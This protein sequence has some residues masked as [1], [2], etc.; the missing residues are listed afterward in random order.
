VI[1][2][3][4]Q[5]APGIDESPLATGVL[6][7]CNCAINGEALGD[8]PQIQSYRSQSSHQTISVK[9]YGIKPRGAGQARIE[10]PVA[11]GKKSL[12]QSQH[13]ESPGMYVY[14]DTRRGGKHPGQIAP[15]P[16]GVHQSF[17]RLDRGK[18]G[19]KNDLNELLIR[20]LR[21]Y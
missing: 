12:R 17:D 21:L 11:R 15:N 5:I 18:R 4:A 10:Y 16:I 20:Y 1:A 3:C 2:E 19:L 9:P 6:Q 13:L 14:V 7:D 8:S